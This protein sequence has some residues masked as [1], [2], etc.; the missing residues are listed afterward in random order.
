MK[1][2][3]ITVVRSKHGPDHVLADTDLPCGTFPYTGQQPIHFDLAADSAEKYLADHFAGIPIE[4][5]G[6]GKFND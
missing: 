5:V 2:T 6:P 4:I 1:I 3:K